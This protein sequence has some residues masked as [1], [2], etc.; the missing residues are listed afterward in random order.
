MRT[1][2]HAVLIAGAFALIAAA[3]AISRAIDPAHSTATFSVQHIFVSNVVGSVPI[4]DGRVTFAPGT[5]VPVSVTATL[6]PSGIV[7]G[8]RDRDAALRGPDWFDVARYP[9]W[10]FVSTTISRT[11]K[12][13]AMDGMLTIHGVSRPE[14]LEVSIAG[15]AE[16]PVYHASGT[17]D[18]HAF[19]MHV[20]RLDPV[21]G[22]PVTIALDI[23]LAPPGT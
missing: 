19:G 17:I 8:D 9:R 7:T 10:T 2:L 16:R 22:N 1:V 13:F 18:R 21:I 12:G 23:V 20:V 3:P 5:R 4:V 14:H 11:A 6:D 15:S